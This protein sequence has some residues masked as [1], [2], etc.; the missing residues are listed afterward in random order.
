MT[1]NDSWLNRYVN[2]LPNRPWFKLIARYIV[3]PFWIRRYP[4]PKLAGGPRAASQPSENVQRMMNLIMPLKDPS[5]MGRAMAT[6]AISHNS[7]AIFTGLDNVGTVHTARFLILGDNLCMISVYDGDFT[8][9]IRDFIET[10]GDVFDEVISQIKGA[11]HLIP[12][13]EHVDEFIQW[14]HEHDLF[15]IP[16]T[17]TDLFELQ[18]KA[19]G[20]PANGPAHELMTLP[21][22]LILQLHA[23]PNLSLG[24]GY[25]SYPGFSTAQ[26]RQKCGV[27]W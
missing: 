3:V 17:P 6:L 25:R 15:Q 27:G 11:E 26:I 21:R 22:A 4:T 14:V 13:R 12:T 24:G 16:E 20:L 7:D 1:S 18:D 23:N 8:N 5:P 10:I 9:Y 19:K 2:N